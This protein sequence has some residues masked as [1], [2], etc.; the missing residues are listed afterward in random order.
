MTMPRVSR[1]DSAL[2]SRTST[3]PMRTAPS[4]V[5]YSRGS[6]WAMVDLPA[7][8]E[9]TRATVWPGSA[10]KEMPC[11]TSAPP[12]VSR[13]GD[14]LQ[15]G[16]GDLVG[17][18]VGEADVV[19]LDGDRALRD[20][21]GVRLLVDERLEVEDLEDALEADQGAHDLDAGARRARSAARRGG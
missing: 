3:P 11:R 4:S 17:G 13:D 16:E 21:A 20:L 9:P 12:R 18:R 2:R 19:E 6:S 15:G 7:P 1:I 5:S 14:L 10:R 8:D